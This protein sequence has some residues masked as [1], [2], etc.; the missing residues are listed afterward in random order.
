MTDFSRWRLLP[1]QL[2]ALAD[3]FSLWDVII[4]TTLCY[5]ACVFLVAHV[6]VLCLILIALNSVNRHMSWALVC[7]S[8][9]NTKMIKTYSLSLLNLL[10]VRET[11]N[12][13]LHI[14]CYQCY[15]SKAWNVPGT[16]FLGPWGRWKQYHIPPS[17]RP[18]SAFHLKFYID[19]FLSFQTTPRIWKSPC[20]H[21]SKYFIWKWQR[22]QK[23]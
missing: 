20:L 15:N 17:Q 5:F 23:S 1:D 6:W 21:L 2:S 12:G 8:F 16:V 19:D 11:T 22:A 10:L 18:V 14:Q 3:E 4:N 7:L 9:H 13:Q